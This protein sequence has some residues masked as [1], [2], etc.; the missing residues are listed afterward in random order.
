MGDVRIA[1]DR[2]FRRNFRAQLRQRDADLR[3]VDHA[4]QPGRLP[5]HN[6]EP[7]V[8]PLTGEALRRHPHLS[9]G[10]E[11]VQRLRLLFEQRHH[12]FWARMTGIAARHEDRVDARQPAVDFGPFL[13]R[14]LDR[15]GIGII[16]VHGRI[17]DPHIDPVLLAD[18]RDFH[19]HFDFG[20]QEVRAVFV[21][22][23]TRRNQLDGVSSEDSQVADVLLE[24]RGRPAVVGIDLGPV[25]KL[26][27]AQRITR[28]CGNLQIVVDGKHL[29]FHAE[30]TQQ[31]P[32]A[33]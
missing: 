21:V 11:L 23:G 9:L 18:A 32:G 1:P 26:V 6:L 10:M 27:A 3:A 22:V 4:A 25:T 13:H 8:H 7:L 33:E 2:I 16:L 17:P 20:Q 24:L 5:V 28:L 29:A 31:I 19:H 15:R 14:E 30:M 12:V